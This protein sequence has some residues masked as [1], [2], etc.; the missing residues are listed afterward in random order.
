MASP[1]AGLP[2]ASQAS[3]VW[4]PCRIGDGDN[5]AGRR[6]AR[7]CGLGTRTSGTHSTRRSAGRD[8]IP[9]DLEASQAA[10]V[11]CRL[12]FGYRFR[13]DQPEALEP[14]E[15][16]FHGDPGLQPGERGAQAEVDPPAEREMLGLSRPVQ[17]ERFG[18]GEPPLVVVAGSVQDEQPGPAG[19]LVPAIPTSR[20]VVRAMPRTEVSCRSPSSTAAGMSP[21]SSVTAASSSGWLSSRQIRLPIRFAVV[22]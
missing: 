12:L 2:A 11:E 22:S 1:A 5:A 6:Q 9:A 20:V 14:G 8:R 10:D 17:P 13:I 4:L 15:Q 7:C 3:A 19:I 16:S 18:V 21:G